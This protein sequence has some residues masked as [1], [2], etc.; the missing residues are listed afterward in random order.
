MKQVDYKGVILQEDVFIESGLSLDDEYIGSSIMKGIK[1]A[2]N[3]FV[4]NGEVIGLPFN[5]Q[6]TIDKFG[7]EIIPSKMGLYHLFLDDRLVYIGMSK[8]LK[9]RLLYHLKD[10]DMVFDNVLWFVSDEI[11]LDLEETL[12]KEKWMIKYHKP[13]LNTIYISAR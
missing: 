2:S 6:Q 7:K 9:G 1:H 8:N 13:P 10:Q 4:Y 5:L 11:G 12:T 3:P